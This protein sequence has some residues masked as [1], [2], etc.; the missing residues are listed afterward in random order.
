MP[1]ARYDRFFGGNAAKALRQMQAKYGTKKGR[2]VFYALINR[3][4]R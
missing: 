1:L 2:Q 3:R 4:K